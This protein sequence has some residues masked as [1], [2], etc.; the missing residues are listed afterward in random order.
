MITAGVYSTLV[1]MIMTQLRSTLG[2]GGGGE[3][4]RQLNEIHIPQCE[5]P[6][7]VFYR[8]CADGKQHQVDTENS[9]SRSTYPI[10]VVPD[11]HQGLQ[12]VSRYFC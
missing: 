3:E 2:G 7:K 5:N 11:G 8:S 10:P 4:C 6:T 1:S 12:P 9:S